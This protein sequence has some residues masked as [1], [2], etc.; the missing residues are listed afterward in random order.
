MHTVS[1]EQPN[2]AVIGETLTLQIYATSVLLEKKA[3]AVWLGN[4]GFQ[5][6]GSAI[7]MHNLIPIRQLNS[8]FVFFLQLTDQFH[9][10]F[11]HS[12]QAT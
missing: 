6:P 9:D 12:A 1:Q 2:K 5:A 10:Q 11:H 3:A 7:T 8:I 4:F